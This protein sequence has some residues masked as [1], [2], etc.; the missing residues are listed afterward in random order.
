MVLSCE[1]LGLSSCGY[2]EN[3]VDMVIYV[4]WDVET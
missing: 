1:G 2:G 3:M 4:V